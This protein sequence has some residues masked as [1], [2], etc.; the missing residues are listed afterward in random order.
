MTI[1]SADVLQFFLNEAD[2][3]RQEYEAKISLPLETRLEKRI[4]ITGLVCDP[5]FRGVVDEGYL[6]KLY[7]VQNISDFKIGDY[8]VLHRGDVKSPVLKCQLYGFAEDGSLIIVVG[9]RQVHLLDD[10]D[11]NPGGLILDKDFP[12]MSSMYSTGTSSIE[13]KDLDIFNY[14]PRPLIE[15]VETAKENL[16]EI[17]NLFGFNLTPRQKEA[18]INAIATRDYYLIQGPPGTG[19]SY[20]ISVIALT[21]LLKYNERVL[22]S[23]PTHLAINNVLAKVV[24]SS[25]GEVLDKVFKI[26]QSYNKAGLDSVVKGELLKIKNHNKAPIDKVNAVD[27]AIFGVTPYHLHTRRANFIEADTIIVDEA[28]QMTVGLALMAMCKGSRIVFVGDHKQLSP[29][30]NFEKHPEILRKS[31]FEHLWNGDNGV[32]LDRS[33]RMN[34]PIC[35]F[36]SGKYYDGQLISHAPDKRMS[37]PLNTNDPVYDKNKPIVIKHIDDNGTFVSEKEAE[38]C[39]NLIDNLVNLYR[40]DPEDIGVISPFRAQG[41]LIRRKL[42]KRN[43]PNYEM[44]LVDTVERMQGQE[45]EFMII[46]MTVGT[47]GYLSEVYDFLNNPHR[48]NVAFSRAKNKLVVL[49]NKHIIG[50]MLEDYK[51]FVVDDDSEYTYEVEYQIDP[52]IDSL[53]AAS[54]LEADEKP[55]IPAVPIDARMDEAQRRVITASQDYNLVLAPPGCGKTEILTHRIINARGQGYEFDDMMCLTFTNRAS[56]GMIERIKANIQDPNVVDMMVGNLHHFCSRFL[57][58]NNLLPHDT[59]II[60]ELDI[61][62]ILDECGIRKIVTDLNVRDLMRNVLAE[63][64]RI[65]QQEHNHPQ[66]VFLYAPL[67]P[68]R[69]HEVQAIA[70]KYYEY[71]KDS[72]LLD[73]DDLLLEAYTALMSPT[74][75]T[76]YEMADYKWIQLDE[77]QDLNPL[78]LAIV[79]KI[80]AAQDQNVMYL[81]DEQQ[82]I[83][84]FMGA[85]LDSLDRLKFRAHDKVLRLEKN[86]RSPKYLLDIFN[87]Y[88]NNELNI[89]LSLL[90]QTDNHIKANPSDLRII[91]SFD[92]NEEAYAVCDEVKKVLKQNP[93]ERIAVLV[94]YNLQADAISALLDNM[95]IGHFKVSGMDVFKTEAYKTLVSHFSVIAK[96]NSYMEWARLMFATKAT[97]SLKDARV[98]VKALRDVGMTPGD[99]LNNANSSYLNDF[100]QAYKDKE[101]VI[102]DT[103]TTGLNVFEDDIIQIAAIKVKNGEKVTGSEFD[104]ILRTDREIPKMLGKKVNPMVAVYNSRDKMEPREGLELFLEYI[105]DAEILGHNASFD[106]NILESNL[107]GYCPGRLL[108][109]QLRRSWDSLKLIRLLQPYLRVYKLESLL[110]VLGLEGVNSHKADDDILATKSLV[111]YIFEHIPAKVEE[112][113]KLMCVAQNIDAARKFAANYKSLYEH[114]VDNLRL[115]GI[116]NGYSVLVDEMEYLYDRFVMEGYLHDHPRMKYVFNFLHAHI[117]G[118]GKG[119]ELLTQ[120]QNH[121]LEL[122]SF[123]EADLCDSSIVKEKVYVMTPYKAKGLEFETVIIYNAVDGTYPFFMNKDFEKIQEDK[124]LFYVAMSRA[125]K[126]LFISYCERFGRFSKKLTP[127]IDNIR[128]YFQE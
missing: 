92:S 56:R 112:Q 3:Q 65:Y 21:L 124:R 103:E 6:R 114:T 15:D 67:S 45:K 83:F 117:C 58:V 60:D 37:I 36:V 104:I 12:D 119:V 29:I 38:Y 127:F 44:I 57:F 30:I 126:R 54:V 50:L 18:A 77:V 90:P 39:A 94:R 51:D 100:Y 87:T 118:M 89:D 42:L 98:F 97:N 2:V 41:A 69:H 73:F 40:V 62:D 24:T 19:K 76:D 32:M 96:D 17:I 47:P 9:N 16:E 91:K 116:D 82:A 13:D 26:G 61:E 122:T 31:V 86:Y 79:D 48:L 93:D 11:R 20:V 78:Q 53:A 101:F 8:L 84:S 34:G 115:P 70:R 14:R 59:C 107:C 99:F 110:E 43:V 25:G 85:K 121:L 52:V 35:S 113:V 120:M 128:G 64:H 74:Y 75:K 46:S 109:W 80:T 63:S 105:G 106:I 95:D 33:F 49:C 5:T 72:H 111:D 81:G 71:K 28:G 10:L 108:P 27:G 4:V 88:A 1:T 7:V 125:K 66:S 102:F 23:G 22:I 68:Q 123:S 55:V